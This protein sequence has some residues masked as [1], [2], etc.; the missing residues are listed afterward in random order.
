MSIKLEKD[1]KTC[2]SV[3]GLAK[4]KNEELEKLRAAGKKL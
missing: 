4:S 3:K 2:P 1:S